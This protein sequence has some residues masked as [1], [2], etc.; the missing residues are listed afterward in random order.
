MYTLILIFSLKS[1]FN[2]NIDSIVVPNLP[3]ITA[4]EKLQL[5]LSS[6]LVSLNPDLRVIGHCEQTK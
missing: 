1:Q 4:C 6:D 2:H 5:L 3:T